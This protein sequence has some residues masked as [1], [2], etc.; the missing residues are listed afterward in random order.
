MAIPQ[1][2]IEE[3]YGVLESYSL[4]DLKSVSETDHDFSS[5]CVP[6][7]ILGMQNVTFYHKKR[8]IWFTMPMVNVLKTMC[9]PCQII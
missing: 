7:T 6:R 5:R 8:T 3:K 4:V 9:L 1:S 2:L